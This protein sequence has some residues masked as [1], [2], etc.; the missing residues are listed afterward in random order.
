MH[1]VLP[2][3][4]NYRWDGELAVKDQ[5]HWCVDNIQVNDCLISVRIYTLFLHGFSITEENV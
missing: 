3:S 5:V 2:E 1:P 4:S